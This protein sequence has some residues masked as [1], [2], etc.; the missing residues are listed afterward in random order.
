[1]Q[2][3]F[4]SN[5]C[6]IKTYLIWY[7]LYSNISYLFWNIIFQCTNQKFHHIGTNYTINYSVLN[8][9]LVSHPPIILDRNLLSWVHISI[10]YRCGHR[11]C[12]A[13]VPFLCSFLLPFYFTRFSSVCFRKGSILH[14][15]YPSGIRQYSV[16]NYQRYSG[17]FTS[18]KFSNELI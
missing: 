5:N 2:I 3:Y 11:V 17:I 8:R 6:E 7:N 4:I 10:R 13:C 14:F 18:C 16:S 1:M 12:K 9:F 15:T